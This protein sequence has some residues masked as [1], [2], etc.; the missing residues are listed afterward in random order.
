MAKNKRSK[1]RRTST[2]VP[3]LA[4]AGVGAF[5]LNAYQSYKATGLNGLKWNTLGIDVS[6][7]FHPKKLAENL[8]PVGVG[9]GGSILASKVGAN[10]M[11]ARIPLIG[12]FISL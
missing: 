12:K 7:K 2:K 10:R 1:S 8:I 5:G 4:A 3:V 9:V 6:G 11:I